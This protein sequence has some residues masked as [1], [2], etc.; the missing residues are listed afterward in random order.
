[1]SYLRPILVEN[2]GKS[3]LLACVHWPS[4]TFHH[5]ICSQSAVVL[6]AG[7]TSTK[8]TLYEWEDYPFRTNGAVK[9]IKEMRET[10][11]ISSHIDQPFQAYD[12]LEEP[13]QILVSGI[14]Q[15]KRS[16]V[17]V[18]LAATAG[19]RLELIKSP[20]ASMDL[21]DIMRRG[22][23]TS[24][25]AVETPNERIRM[26]SGSEEGLFGWV[27]VN[28]IVGAITENTQVAPADTVGSLDLGGAS[29]QI[30]FVAKTR[31]PT[32][33]ASM[34]Y[35]PLELF[36]RQYSVYSHSFLCYGK[37][38]FERRIQAS[39]IVSLSGSQS[40]SRF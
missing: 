16:T 19:M 39:L 2:G 35:Y 9:Q 33:E 29:T 20:L 24:G 26:L 28:N 32:R 34:D 8:L 37:N 40:L 22:L 18:Y 13:L 27:S 30:A 23:R 14:P 17:P 21:F 7:S 36:G 11:G 38:E 6:D 1:L 31:P 5:Y 4:Q 12:Q 10:P 15:N 3:F 25:L